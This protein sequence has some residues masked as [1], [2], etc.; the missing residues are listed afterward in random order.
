M[1]SMTFLPRLVQV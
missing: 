1:I